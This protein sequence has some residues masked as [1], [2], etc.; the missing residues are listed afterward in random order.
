MAQ[1]IV[2]NID[3]DVKVR[4]KQRANQHG[5]SME[6]IR[7]ILRRSV[8]EKTEVRSKFGTRIAARFSGM[9]MS[10]EILRCKGRPFIPWLFQSDYFGYKRSICV[11]AT[12]T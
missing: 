2:R 4:L 5:W 1:M 8:K 6:E 10:E 12:A 11:A 9:G 7:Q 3:E